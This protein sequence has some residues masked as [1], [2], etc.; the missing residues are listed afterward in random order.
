MERSGPAVRV[1]EEGT[2]NWGV[3]RPPDAPKVQLTL[4]IVQLMFSR[5]YIVNYYVL[6]A[7]AIFY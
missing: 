3:I 4:Y 2:P 1:G 6:T 7:S 5:N